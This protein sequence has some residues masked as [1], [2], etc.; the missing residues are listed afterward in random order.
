MSLYWPSDNRCISHFANAPSKFLA[1]LRTSD[2]P[3]TLSEIARVSDIR[4]VNK[5]EY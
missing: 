1:T 4:G 3:G 2:I 5:N